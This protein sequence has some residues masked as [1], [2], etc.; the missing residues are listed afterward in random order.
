[1]PI[2]E[3]IKDLLARASQAAADLDSL[4]EDLARATTQ[5]QAAQA[6]EE[7]AAKKVAEAEAALGELLSAIAADMRPSSSAPAQPADAAD[8]LASILGED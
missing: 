5:R 8:E 6:V 1:M 3:N 4:K 2:P 7:E